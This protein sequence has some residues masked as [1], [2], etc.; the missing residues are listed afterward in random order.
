MSFFYKKNYAKMRVFLVKTIKFRDSWELCPQTPQSPPPLFR[1]KNRFKLAE[2]HRYFGDCRPITC[3]HETRNRKHVTT[4]SKTTVQEDT[5]RFDRSPKTP[6][7][8]PKIYEP[9]VK[10]SSQKGDEESFSHCSTF[11]L[12]SQK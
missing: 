7:Q 1:F 4:T 2:F 12:A 5:L 6:L 10:N 3:S 9:R 8:T 11:G